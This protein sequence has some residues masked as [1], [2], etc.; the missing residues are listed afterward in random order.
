HENEHE[1]EHHHDHNL[2]AAYL[3]VLADALT[4][5]LAIVALIIGKFYG[6]IWLDALMGIVGALV[7]GKWTFG[8]VKQTA[9][10]LLDESIESKYLEQLNQTLIPY[11]TVTDLHVWRISAHHYGAIISLV[12]HSETS[13]EEYKH[14]LEKFDKIHHLT[15][16]LQPAK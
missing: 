11:A 3:H 7:I 9:P 1:H 16:E 2:R 6:W 8:L 13:Y 15:L 14:M 12:D 4:S 5:I 10:I